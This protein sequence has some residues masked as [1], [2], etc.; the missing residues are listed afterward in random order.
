MKIRKLFIYL[1]LLSSISSITVRAQEEADFKIDPFLFNPVSKFVT[2]EQWKEITDDLNEQREQKIKHERMFGQARMLTVDTRDQASCLKLRDQLEKNSALSSDELDSFCKE[3]AKSPYSSVLVT[4]SYESK[5]IIFS[6]LSTEQQNIVKQTRNFA[7]LGAGVI[8]LLW[9]M[10]ESVTK[11]DKNEIG[12]LGSK[13]KE[14]I[15]AGPVW[16]KD[17]W[18]VNLI[19]HP[20]SGAAYHVVARKAGLTPMQSFG[21]GVFMSTIFWEYGLEAAAEIPSIQD[22]ILTPVVGSL[23]GESFIKMTENIEKNGGKVLGSKKLGSVAMALMDPAGATLRGINKLFDGNFIKDSRVF[24]YNKPV[25]FGEGVNTYS[26]N[27]VG[28]GI[29]LKF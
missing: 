17:D 24:M 28:I 25:S 23:L 11:W 27:V 2:K 4:E 14:N 5:G 13:Y 15:K 20:Y 26:E 29:E 19:G 8:G 7:V 18:A 12:S 3:D 6:E 9:M 21:Y 1:S 10:P 22:L 16:D